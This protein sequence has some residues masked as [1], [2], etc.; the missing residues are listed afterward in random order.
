MAKNSTSL[1][2]AA[3]AALAESLLAGVAP[4]VR[5][6]AAGCALFRQGDTTFAVFR[7]VSGRIRLI[8]VTPQGAE[9]PMHTARPGELFAE[10]SIFSDRYHCDA[11]AVCDCAVLV[12]AKAELTLRFRDSAEDLWAFAAEMA[13]RIQALRTGLEL[14]QI[15]S[16]P[17]R[18]LQYLRLRCD[19]QGRWKLDGTLKQLAEDVGLT[20]EALYRALATLER[21]SR[22]VRGDQEIELVRP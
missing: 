8:R 1:P 12:Y 9:V 3:P 21:D 19:A 2:A 5:K 16:A 20:H 15:R 14:R 10:A 13:R 17:E 22:I 18:V 11:I 6:V 7:V 4:T